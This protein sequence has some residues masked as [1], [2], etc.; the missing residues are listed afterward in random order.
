MATNKELIKKADLALSDLSGGTDGGL[1]QPEQANTFIRKLLIS[2][3]I[4]PRARVVVMKGPSKKI[5]KIQ[6]GSRIMMPV[7]AGRALDVDTSATNRRS[8]PTTY[9]I[10]LDTKEVIAE[11]RIPYEV[12]EDNIEGGT[13]ATALQQ[14]AGG[15]HQTL[16]EMIAERAALD[17]E[18]LALKGD[19]ASG[20]AY[21]ALT[22]GWLKLISSN[23]V[24]AS[25]ATI[26]KDLIKAAVKAMPDQFLR[27][28]ASMSH[29]FSVDNVTELRDQY[30]NRPTGLGD[31]N[32][33]G[34]LPLQMFG[35][36][37]NECAMMPAANGLFCN[38]KNLIFGIQRDLTMEYDKDITSRVFIIVVHARVAVQI[39]E[40]TA[41]VKYTTLA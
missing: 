39:E 21:L 2:P 17:L 27:D 34:A 18:E 20:D 11:V 7:P 38:P 30:S 32:L 15:L 29:F 24:N 26:S 3:T 12:L 19:T 22:D 40:E 5:N 41:T 28:R 8:K 16:V 25:S 13:V 23:V 31:Q 36:Q 37:I 10:S 14:G 1:L 33:T 4:L 35:S 6:F 9:Q